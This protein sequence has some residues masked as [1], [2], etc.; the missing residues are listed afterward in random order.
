MRLG[1]DTIEVLDLRRT[2]FGYLRLI[3]RCCLPPG[4]QIDSAALL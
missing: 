2:C 3:V 1:N 4:V